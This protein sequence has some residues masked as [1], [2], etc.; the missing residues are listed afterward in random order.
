MPNTSAAADIACSTILS[1]PSRPLTLKPRLA[2]PIFIAETLVCAT[3]QL[4]DAVLI[5]LGREIGGLVLAFRAA[6]SGSAETP[7]SQD[8]VCSQ[9]CC[10]SFFL[11]LA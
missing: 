3:N 10:G 2:T 4:Q 8:P 7:I 11:A 9:I 5:T 6:G 1:L